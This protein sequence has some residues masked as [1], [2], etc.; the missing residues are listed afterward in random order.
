MGIF[1]GNDLTAG[2]FQVWD[3]KPITYNWTGWWFGTME[4]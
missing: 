4:F 2:L 3:L 1:M